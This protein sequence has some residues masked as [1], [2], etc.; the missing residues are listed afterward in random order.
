MGC[1]QSRFEQRTSSTGSSSNARKALLVDDRVSSAASDATLR[2]G[3]PCS[4]P[5]SEGIT[6]EGSSAS[7]CLSPLTTPRTIPVITTPV[8]TSTGMFKPVKTN[9]MQGGM[10]LMA[11]PRKGDMAALK[12]AGCHAVATLQKDHEGAL[13]IKE[14]AASLEL[15]SIHEDFWLLY[16]GKRAK[17]IMVGVTRAAE[18]IRSG[19][20]VMIHCTA[21]I[22]R[23]GMFAYSVLRTLG[24][25]PRAAVQSLKNMRNI[26]FTRVGAHRIQTIEKILS[27]SFPHPL[28]APMKISDADLPPVVTRTVPLPVLVKLLCTG[29]SVDD[30]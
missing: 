12:K 8:P 15:E 7:D 10:C 25:T 20:N 29:Q 26:T 6:E 17:E 13:D 14:Q 21:G 22:H 18:L 28:P 1:E 24:Y 4:A 9:E 2:R 30:L 11:F 19:K 3:P 16:H 27:N 23:T 5:S